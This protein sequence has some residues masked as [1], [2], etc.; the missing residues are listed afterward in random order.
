[1]ELPT[2]PKPEL[3][4]PPSVLLHVPTQLRMIVYRMTVDS[5]GL[6]MPTVIERT[7]GE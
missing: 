4:T 3:G 1:M 6:D 7:L 5:V 2:V